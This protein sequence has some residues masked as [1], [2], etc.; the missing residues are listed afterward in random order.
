MVTNIDMLNNALIKQFSKSAGEAYLN[1][2][3]GGGGYSFLLNKAIDHPLLIVNMLDF[4]SGIN[5]KL[6]MDG[7]EINFYCENLKKII[8]K[9]QLKKVYINH[10]IW[11]NHFSEVFYEIAS[12]CSS[13][14]LHIYLHDFFTLCPTV[15]LLDYKG[16]YCGVPYYTDCS[17]CIN[18]YV[19]SSNATKFAKKQMSLYLPELGGDIRNWRYLW[20]KIFDQA[21]SIIV[22]SGSTAEIFR[23]AYGGQYNQKI[24]VKPHGVKETSRINPKNQITKTSFMNVYLLGYIDEHKGFKILKE[25]IDRTADARINVCYHVLGWFEYDKYVDSPFLKLH[26]GYK[27]EQLPGLL[28]ELEIDMFIQPSI[29]PETF[30]YVIHEM[31]ATN[32]P[33]LAFNLG[34]QADF[35]TDYKPAVL[36]YEISARAMFNEIMKMY[37]LHVKNVYPVLQLDNQNR[38]IMALVKLLQ[39]ENLEIAQQHYLMEKLKIQVELHEGEMAAKNQEINMKNNQIENILDDINEIIFMFLNSRSW[40]FAK[41]V[42]QIRSWFKKIKA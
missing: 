23:R 30:S 14:E 13:I 38:E 11:A 29:C 20:L 18:N 9:F 27:A 41:P 3:D 6:I 33:I 17:N 40:K 1:T 34:A 8:D 42:R 19:Q 7:K 21:V 28:N 12:A 10:L 2:L 4:K 32:L 16:K 36:V 5:A 37:D 31:K 22:P 25:L 26:G 35:L 24:V 39:K 15:N